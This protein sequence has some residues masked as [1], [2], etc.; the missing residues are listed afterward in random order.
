MISNDS[1]INEL[2]INELTGVENG[3]RKAEDVLPVI[4]DKLTKLPGHVNKQWR[5]GRGASESRTRSSFVAPV[6]P[7]GIWYCKGIH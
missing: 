2:F 1:Q 6:R 7:R 4:E 5:I 3:D